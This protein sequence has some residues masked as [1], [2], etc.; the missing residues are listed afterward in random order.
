MTKRLEVS[1]VWSTVE[2][3]LKRPSIIKTPCLRFNVSRQDQWRIMFLEL[4][5][6]GGGGLPNA[7]Q[8]LL[9]RFQG[10]FFSVT[11]SLG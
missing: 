8:F 2:A 3:K 7:E 1:S 4:K 5:K 11:D 10:I 9:P 6:L